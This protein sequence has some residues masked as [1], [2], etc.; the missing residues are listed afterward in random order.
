MTKML[1]VRHS[2]FMIQLKLIQL[3]LLTLYVLRL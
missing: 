2:T 1:V 3:V